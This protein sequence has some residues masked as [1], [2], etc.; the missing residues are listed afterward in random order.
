MTHF[1]L[2]VSPSDKTEFVISVSKK[3]AKQAVTRNLIKRR[4]RP[5]LRQ[6]QL[7]PARYLIVVRAGAEEVK[8]AAL[9]SELEKLMKS[10]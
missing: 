10:R 4:I 7:P 2:R 5:I 1:S 9:R 8:G 3:V 6:Y